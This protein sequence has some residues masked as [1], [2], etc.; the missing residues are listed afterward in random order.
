MLADTTD[1][2]RKDAVKI[3]HKI[4]FSA[5]DLALLLSALCY[6]KKHTPLLSRSCRTPQN[7]IAFP[8]E[9]GYNHSPP[10]K[11]LSKYTDGA[12]VGQSHETLRLG[13]PLHV[14]GLHSPPQRLRPRL[15]LLL[16][17]T[18]RDASQTASREELPSVVPGETGDGRTDVECDELVELA[19]VPDDGAALVLVGG[20]EP[21]A[22]FGE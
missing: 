13:A 6:S 10:E 5:A 12:L 9:T 18:D 11:P 22:V 16:V 14:H 2:V 17:L 21:G 19:E 20:G 8:T 1:L 4:A 7:A 15:A 3:Y